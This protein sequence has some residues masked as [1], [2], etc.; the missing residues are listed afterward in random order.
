VEW[1]QARGDGAVYA[2][3]VQYKPGP[4]RDAADGPYAVALID[5]DEGVRVMGNVLGCAPEDVHVGM[6][7]RAIWHALSDGRQLL[8]FAPRE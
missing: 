1:R 3:S 2:V 7:V 6:P 5:L 4:G 8:Q